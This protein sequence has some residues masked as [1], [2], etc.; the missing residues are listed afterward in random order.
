MPLFSN[1]GFETYDKSIKKKKNDISEKK[2]NFTCNNLPVVEKPGIP[3][4]KIKI[5][6]VQTTFGKTFKKGVWLFKGFYISG[7]YLY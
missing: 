3:K 5:K 1:K 2:N 6:H 4:F 7:I